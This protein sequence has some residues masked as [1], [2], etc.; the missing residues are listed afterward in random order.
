MELDRQRIIELLLEVS[1]DPQGIKAGD[2]ARL[3]E[4]GKGRTTQ[5]RHL[6]QAMTKE[7]LVVRDGRRY[8]IGP[9]AQR[10]GGDGGDDE[11]A[12]VDAELGDG[13]RIAGTLQVSYHGRAYIDRGEA[14]E[15]VRL[16]REG[17]GA[18]IDGDRVEAKISQR[19]RRQ[20]AYI[21]KVLE[22]GRKRLTGV[23]HA[24]P[25]WQIEPDDPRL[26][27]PVEVR[28]PADGEP[29]EVVLG[30]II[31]Y[32]DKHGSPLV[33]DVTQRLGEPGD[34][35]TEIAK[36]LAENMIEEVFP[37]AVRS[38]LDQVPDHVRDEDLV[39]RVD[40]R[41]R[42]FVTIDPRTARDFDDAVAV[43]P[44]PD[45]TTRVW[46]AVADVSH[47]VEP[48][49]ATDEEAR[50]RGCSVYLPDRAIPMLPEPL[51]SGI[52]S[53]V[54]HQDRLAMVVRLDIADDGDVRDADA[55]AAVIHSHG[56]LDYDGVAAALEGDFRGRRAAY[57]DHAPTLLTMQRVA[58]ALRERRLARGSLDLD[59]PEAKVVLDEDDPRRVRDIVASRAD[60]PLK[61]AYNLIEE[62]MIAAN[63][64]VGRLF[65]QR[66]LPTLWRIHPEPLA[67]AIKMLVAWLRSYGVRVNESRLRKP[68]GMAEL[69]R[70]LRGHTAQRPLSY[71]V[72]RTLK[73]ATYN[74]ENVGHYGLASETYLHF[75]SPIRRY[76]DLETHR[77]LKRL[78]RAEGRPAGGRQH[79]TTPT[80]EQLAQVA[81]TSSSLERRALDVERA[82]H[83]LYAAHMVKDLIGEV[84]DGLITGITKFGFFVSLGEPFVDGLVKL[85]TLDDWYEYEETALRLFGRDGH[86]ISLGDRLK[87]RVV[88]TSVSRRQIDLEVVEWGS[89]VTGR[90]SGAARKAK[91][92]KDGGKPKRERAE[93]P[94]RRRR[95]KR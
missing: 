5:L 4:L 26:P 89:S 71:L 16:A 77:L 85:E 41:D 6:L 7:G 87:V 10:G 31:D 67:N 20:E 24:G 65:E 2:L 66:G 70:R 22:R 23:L 40:L 28:D 1:K 34:L 13:S 79:G 46:I 14:Y 18:A 83:S 91:K 30:S 57:R 44:G 43:E 60:A 63:E 56:R 51:S 35:L 81:D 75:T 68:E 15:R 3:L 94:A 58:H 86:V 25:P 17:F 29:G 78:L 52:C 55:T 90:D 84:Y 62:M 38:E 11:G 64:A 48:G 92:G 59:L 42:P 32:P 74:V 80:E 8:R 69:L 76:P 36:V 72:L 88:E 50:R 93:P 9:Q 82:V 45:G 54:P 53:L 61:R 27:A 49:T 21:V 47:Y 39:D 33:V 73:Q 37:R 12:A 19:G 95:R